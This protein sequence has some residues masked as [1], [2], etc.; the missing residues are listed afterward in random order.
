M[1]HFV[2]YRNIIIILLFLKHCIEYYE[3]KM[4]PWEKN[5]E[6][7]CQSTTLSK[8]NLWFTIG[9]ETRLEWLWP[10]G[11]TKPQVMGK[12][13]N[14]SYDRLHF[15]RK[16]RCNETYSSLS[17]HHFDQFILYISTTVKWT[18]TRPRFLLICNK[19]PST[20]LQ[21]LLQTLLS[22]AMYIWPS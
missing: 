21:F 16:G 3:T 20:I 11:C 22:K 17:Q 12:C 4:S 6:V 14:S 9:S 7:C 1:W 10:P 15:S 8:I 13:S 2:I 18:K 19:L 5:N